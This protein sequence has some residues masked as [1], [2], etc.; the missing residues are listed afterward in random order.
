[1]R[2]D[3]GNNLNLVRRGSVTCGLGRNIFLYS[4]KQAAQKIRRRRRQRGGSS[5]AL[6]KPLTRNRAM[7][8][9]RSGSFTTDAFDTRADQCPLLLQ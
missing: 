3:N 5:S 9:V 1:M 4:T 7:T 6:D 2:I 8:H